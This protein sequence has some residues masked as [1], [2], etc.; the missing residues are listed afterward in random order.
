MWLGLNSISESCLLTKVDDPHDINTPLVLS[1]C[2]D[3]IFE[4]DLEPIFSLDSSDN[5]IPISEEESCIKNEEKQLTK[6]IRWRITDKTRW[7]RNIC[8]KS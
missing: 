7:K 5:F 4:S 8:N 6:L 1:D 2:E 3:A